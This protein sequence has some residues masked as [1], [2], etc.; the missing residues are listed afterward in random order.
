V[1]SSIRTVF[2][3]IGGVILTNGWDP[4]QRR[5]V[6]TRLGVDLEAYEEVHDRANYYWERG[7]ITAEDFFSQTVLKPNPK[8]KLTFDILWPQVCAESKVLHAECLD[9]LAE[10]KESGRYRL[11]TL[12][13]ES[14][15][16]NEHRLDAFKL[17]SLFDY[18][19]CSGY[20]HEMKPM[21][22]IYKSAIAISGFAASTALFIDDKAE[23]CEAAAA[24]GMNTIVF[25]SPAQL[26]ESLA[27]YDIH[28]QHV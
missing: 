12:N 1:T 13:N 7:L 25:K 28:L 20:V 5:R 8:L 18:F 17:R 16:L 22:G 6:L 19:I 11:A 4:Q 2:W 15:E 9:L 23:N 10:L 14:Q 21:P 3:D 27:T 24:L 26:C